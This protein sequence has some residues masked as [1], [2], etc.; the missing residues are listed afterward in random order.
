MN[1][2]ESKYYNTA[3][4]MNQALIELLNIKEYEFIT[5]KEIC[6]KAG[7]N[8]STFYLHYETKEDLLEECLQNTNKHFL[9]YFNKNE[10][11]FTQ[12]LKTCP[13]EDLILITHDYL[14]PYLKYIKENKII[15]QVAVKNKIVMNTVEK[16]NSLNKYVF[17]PIFTRFGIDEKSSRYIIMYYLNGVNAIINEWILNDCKDE[18]EFI[19]KII[20]DCIRPYIKN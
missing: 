10:T 1:K 6:A 8:R 19:E 9:T 5:I 18:I 4:L 7:V 20:I 15:H 12:K 17:R 16:F 3:L 13:L 2:A 14:L 11:E